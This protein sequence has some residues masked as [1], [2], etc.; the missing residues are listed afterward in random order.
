MCSHSPLPIYGNR[1]TC[2]NSYHATRRVECPLR[3]PS[4]VTDSTHKGTDE[5]LLLLHNQTQIN[6]NQVRPTIPYQRLPQM[7]QRAALSKPQNLAQRWM[8]LGLVLGGEALL[9]FPSDVPYRRLQMAAN[10]SEKTTMLMLS[11]NTQTHKQYTL[12]K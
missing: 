6:L 12:S 1:K 2:N 8:Q 11:I 9:L 5:T 3:R 10:P 7:M 4:I